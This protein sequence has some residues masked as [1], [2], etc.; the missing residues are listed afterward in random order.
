MKQIELDDKTMFHQ[1][2][3]DINAGKQESYEHLGV[4]LEWIQFC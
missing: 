3:L 2:S 1:S 4:T